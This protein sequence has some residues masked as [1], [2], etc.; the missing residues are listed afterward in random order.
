MLFYKIWQQVTTES[1]MSK[2]TGK[3]NWKK[4]KLTVD[5]LRNYMYPTRINREVGLLFSLP[6]KQVTATIAVEV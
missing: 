1:K 3:Y 5:T 6:S 4:R 2:R